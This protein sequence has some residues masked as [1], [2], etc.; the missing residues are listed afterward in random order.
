MELENIVIIINDVVCLAAM[1][2]Y[3]YSERILSN[4]EIVQHTHLCKGW[5]PL[6]LDLCNAHATWAALTSWRERQVTEVG[7]LWV[8]ALTHSFLP[9]M[10]GY[11]EH[12]TQYTSLSEGLSPKDHLIILRIDE[13]QN[14]MK[15]SYYF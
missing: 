13:P 6:P 15:R 11:P 8:F 9:Q 4:C 7:G 2:L 10:L 12:L 3:K 14:L 5:S 1:S